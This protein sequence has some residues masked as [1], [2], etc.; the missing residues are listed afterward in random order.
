M[1]KLQ[2]NRRYSFA[3]SLSFILDTFIAF[4]P[5]K[6][7]GAYVNSTCTYADQYMQIISSTTYVDKLLKVFHTRNPLPKSWIF[8]FKKLF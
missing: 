3:Q 5:N 2:V 1:Y 4:A 6:R 7:Y 8:I